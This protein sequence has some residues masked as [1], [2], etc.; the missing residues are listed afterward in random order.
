MPFFFR[1][2]LLALCALSALAGGA[3]RA[4]DDVIRHRIPNS[5]F[6]IAAAVEIPTTVSTIYLSGQV[7]PVQDAT[8]PR[9]N[10]LAY[11]G[12]TKAQTVGVLKS[13]EKSLAG[14]GLGLG[15]VVKMQVFLVG[16]PAKD[17][18]M[19][20]AGF[21]EGYTQFFGTKEQPNLPTRS[22]F[23]VMALANT[24]WRVEIEVVAARRK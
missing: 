13:I 23:Q 5:T 19:D 10:P 2:S 20:F 17:N 9:D 24:A 12:D 21:M 7:P 4:A 16:D 11:G 8:Q 14:L 3:A 18:K 1:Q 22:V 15:D 6:P